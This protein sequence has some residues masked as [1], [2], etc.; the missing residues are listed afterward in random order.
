MIQECALHKH[1]RVSYDD[2]QIMECPLCLTKKT[3]QILDLAVRY[4]KN[5]LLWGFDYLKVVSYKGPDKLQR[6][7]IISKVYTD[8]ETANDLYEIVRLLEDYVALR[9]S[10]TW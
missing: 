7:A 8:M 4:Y 1:V 2:L 10:F 5:Y 6:D 9:K 3:I